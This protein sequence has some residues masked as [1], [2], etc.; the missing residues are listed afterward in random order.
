MKVVIFGLGYVGFTAACCVASEGHHVTG[1]DVSPKK[2][3]AVRAGRSP[4]VEPGVDAMLKDGLARGLIEADTGIGAHLDQADLAI[5]C[6][7]TP[8]GPDG[9]HNMAYIAD[10]S[11]QIA[12]ALK[13]DDARR[14]RSR[15]PTARRSARARSRS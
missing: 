6:V 10:V 1:I 15:S 11:R 4:I 5:V 3:E 13:G 2:V 14:P 12:Q 9:S 8:S 7:G